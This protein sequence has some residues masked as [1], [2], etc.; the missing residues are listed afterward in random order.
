M[1]SM[2]DIERTI[3]DDAKKHVAIADDELTKAKAHREAA[4]A[5][6]AGLEEHDGPTTAH[7]VSDGFK[8]RWRCVDTR[9]L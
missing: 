1:L 5:T 2:I 9:R 6:P 4:V 8:C 3:A 7:Q